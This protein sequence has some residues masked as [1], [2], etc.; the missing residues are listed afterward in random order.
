MLTIAEQYRVENHHGQVD[1]EHTYLGDSPAACPSG[2]TR[3]MSMPI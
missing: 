2:S 3:D 1:D